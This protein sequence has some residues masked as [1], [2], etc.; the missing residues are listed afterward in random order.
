MSGPNTLLLYA[1]SRGLP[2]T[3]GVLAATVVCVFWRVASM[4]SAGSAD[5]AGSSWDPA[6][7]KP[8]VIVGPLL[9]AAAIGTSLYTYSDELDRTSV[10]P[11]WPRRLTQLAGLTA[12]S[13]AAL[14]IAMPGATEEFGAGAMVRNTLG[15]V[16]LA[17]LSAVV[18]GA[19]LSWAPPLAYLATIYLGVQG[20]GSRWTAVWAWPLQP[21]PGT[22]SWVTALLLLAT[23]T[24]AYTVF[25]ARREHP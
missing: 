16:G 18:I 14:G 22:A 7:E 9:V 4:S 1:R 12:A 8:L 6:L 17:V 2:V 19:R 25:G 13:A 23:A 20:A 24:I 21:G 5:S 3:L 11:W 15:V 10:R